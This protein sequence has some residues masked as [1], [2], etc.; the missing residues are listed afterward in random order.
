MAIVGNEMR[1][2]LLV[3][4]SG[5][6]GQKAAIQAAKLGKRVGLVERRTVVGGVCINTGTIPSKSLRLAVLH[7]SGF[8]ERKFYGASYCVKEK[9]TMEDLISR[10][11]QV[12]ENEIQVIRLQLSRNG[13][14]LISGAARFSGPNTVEVTRPD[15]DVDRY[16]AGTFIIAVGTRPARPPSIPF[17]DGFVV[18]SDGILRLGRIPKTMAVVGAGVIGIEYASM[19]SALGVE[20]TVVEKRPSMLEFVDGEIVDDLQYQLRDH[21]VTFRFGEEVSGIAIEG[22]KVRVSLKSGKKILSEAVLHSTGRQG[23]TDDLGLETIGLAPDDR[24]RLKVDA[25]FR[26]VVPHV[27]AVGDVIG[28][29]SLASTSM[30]QGRLAA[31]N[32]YG[33]PASAIP[34][35]FPYGI[36]SIPEISMVGR[37]EE[38]LTRD[39]VPY[40]VGRARYREISRGQLV[41]DETG[42]LKLL[43][44]SETRKLLGVHAIGTDATELI[45]VGQAVLSFGGSLDYFVRTVFNYPTLAECYKVAAL[46]ALNK[47]GGTL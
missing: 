7:L 30:E 22:G 37:S 31:C 1:Y 11:R 9:I 36:F 32:A 45:H 23:A 41:G 15:G 46:D 13:V 18:D 2:D 8:F 21:E 5:P 3:I 4:G 39:A 12:I 27:F 43:F 20:V 35:L 14:D 17:Q 44:H 28:F 10:T 16:E 42:L 34:E 38:E 33:V 40:E 29:P 24:G 25:Q 47:L 6:A 26:T 19:F